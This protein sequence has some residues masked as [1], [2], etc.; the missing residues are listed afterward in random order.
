MS[1][2]SPSAFFFQLLSGSFLLGY[3]TVSSSAPGFTATMARS[4]NP[5]PITVTLL[6]C[7]EIARRSYGA[8]V[9]TALSPGNDIDSFAAYLPPLLAQVTERN[10]GIRI[11]GCSALCASLPEVH[12]RLG[13]GFGSDFLQIP[14]WLA[15]TV[16]SLVGQLL[17]VSSGTLVSA[18]LFPP[19]Q[20]QNRTSTG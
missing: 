9:P 5:W 7:L 11:R 16:S 10:S 1:R 6:R 2:P 13:C 18:Y 15:P 20:G 4:A 14:H 3:V 19:F 12:F 8:S 17:R